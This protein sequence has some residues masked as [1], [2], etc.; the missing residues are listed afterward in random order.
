MAGRALKPGIAHRFMGVL[1]LALVSGVLLAS[2][3][4]MSAATQN[5]A[6][7]GR[8]YSWLLVFNLLGVIFLLA[9]IALNLMNLAEQW[10]AGALGSRL[11]LRLL[12]M[13]TLLSVLP[14]TIVF[15]FSLQTLNR[16]I[17]HWFDVKIERALDD[18]LALGRTA[19][20]A[21]K[22]DLVKNA[23]EMAAEI[24]LVAAGDRPADRRVLAV[25][26]ELRERYGVTELTLFAPDGKIIASS[27]ELG[28]EAAG[29]IV[30]DRPGETVLAQVR[31]GLTYAA[32][33]PQGGAGGGLRLRVATP[34]YGPEV[35]SPIRVLQ[36]LVV[37]PPR[38]TKLGESVQTA[39]AEYEKLVYLRGPLKFGFTLTLSLVALFA[40]LVAVW[41]A[42]VSARRLTAPLRDLAEGVR[43]VARGD[44]DQQLPVTSHDEIGVL[45]ES[46]NDM[47]R[48]IRRAQNQIQRSQEAAE[49]ARAY[50]ETVLTHLSS[51]VLSF[52][53]RGILRTYNE[54]AENIL[55]VS[56]A[57]AAGQRLAAL[58][59]LYPELGSFMD[60]VQRGLA[61][62]AGEWQ[63]EVVVGAPSS[64]T[65][66]L[67]GTRLPRT[68]PARRAAAAK[69][70]GGGHVVVFDDITALIQAQ[71]DAAWREVARRMAHEIKNPLTPIQLS[72]ERV[73]HKYLPLLPEGERET[74]ERAT[75]TIIEQVESLK[76]LVNAFSDYARAE[77]LHPVAVNLNDL[78]RDVVE[79]Y[80]AELVLGP[81]GGPAVSFK[82]ELD[83]AVPVIEAD[84]GRL[85]QV[86][87]NLLINARD[88]LASTPHPEVRIRTRALGVDGGGRA[89]GA[90]ELRVEDNGPGFDERLL[91][92]L[93]EPYVTNKEKGTGLGLAIVKRIVEEHGG[94]VLAENLAQGGAS[95]S[96]RLPAAVPAAGG[97]APEQEM[98]PAA[99][100]AAVATVRRGGGRGR[101]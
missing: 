53:A 37:L 67:R 66:L 47:T 90:V 68:L 28:P 79:M 101:T 77:A 99:V 83:P 58:A 50:L 88:A 4:M 62:S 85:R 17:D 2:L 9:L 19:I 38:Y 32:L 8:M 61:E 63:A 35:G 43:A 60:A 24:E 89:A 54:A 80:R 95:V 57:P 64:R 71:R 1:P 82:L 11:T 72:A 23:R 39:F 21:I 16:G 100:A 15:F 76:T 69:G 75:R 31:Q 92:R 44:Y 14:V 55:G 86:L 56:L 7:F 42:I 49:R 52:D 84:A 29:T 33:D 97:A 22:Q 6:L 91:E 36:A 40:M 27:S 34:V 94:T 25:L 12:T 20:D 78:V 87:H 73:R 26:N 3:L 48:R 70:R 41:A 96:I 81:G 98:P 74:L 45:V 93:F 18:A 51:G 5:S 10:R 46:F 13:F 65:L 59:R 30:P